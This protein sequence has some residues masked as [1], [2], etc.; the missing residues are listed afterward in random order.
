M[1]DSSLKYS[2]TMSALH[3]VLGEFFRTVMIGI[4]YI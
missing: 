2:K 3:N 4:L 1:D